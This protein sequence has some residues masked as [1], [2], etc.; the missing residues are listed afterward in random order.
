MLNTMTPMRILPT[1]TKITVALINAACAVGGLV[2]GAILLG[3]DAREQPEPLPD[4]FVAFAVAS[5]LAWLASVVLLPVALRHDDREADLFADFPGPRASLI[6][7]LAVVFCGFSYFTAPASVVAFINLTSRRSIRWSALSLVAMLIALS[8]ERLFPLE[9][10]EPLA[11]WEYPVATAL[12]C[13]PML[14]WGIARGRAREKKMQLIHLV[15]R[16]E[17]DRIARDMHDSL[18]HRLSLIAVHAGALSYREDL[19]HD[20]V[21]HAAE[22]IRAQA[23]AAVGDLRAVL[24]T[25]DNPADR[26]ANS[27][28]DNPANSLAE[29][30][31]EVIA[32]AKRAGDNIDFDNQLAD[33]AVLDTRTHHAAVRLLQEALTNARKHAPGRPVGVKVWGRRGI[34]T[35]QVTNPRGPGAGAGTGRGIIGMRE[36]ASAVGATLTIDDAD[37]FIVTVQ[38]PAKVRV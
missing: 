22:T 27:P 1:R 7:G 5:A 24:Q 16:G 13:A 34:V 37:P 12:V 21:R 32:E 23:E 2:I 14:L 26:P 10:V 30:V 19:P 31:A 17:R 8:T 9:G 18:S 11:M 28:A 35:L 3:Y 25:V 38:L 20:Q 36:R 33:P 15:Q 6:A 4:A 29:S